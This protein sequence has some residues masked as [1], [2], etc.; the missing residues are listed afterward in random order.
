MQWVAGKTSDT[1]TSTA[2]SKCYVFCIFYIT[3][4]YKAGILK[5]LC[6][7][8]PPLS[9]FPFLSP[10]GFRKLCLDDL[11]KPPPV[12]DVQQYILRRLDQEGSLRR[13]LT[14]ETADMLNLL[15]IKSGGCFLFLER[16]LDGV[17]GALVGLRE[18]RDIP[19]TLN[20][21]YLWLCQRL[22]P[23]EI[24]RASCRERV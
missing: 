18:I 20:G 9:H 12:R 7:A 2:C 8:Y 11:R 13:Q 4:K 23:R 19:G 15:H 3:Q 1:V 21:L 6:R 14:P 22:F 5:T 16:V 10:P 24:G 17:A